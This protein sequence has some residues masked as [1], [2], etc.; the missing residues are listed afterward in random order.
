MATNDSGQQQIDDLITRLARIAD[1]S[2][3]GVDGESRIK[4]A[5]I[6]AY[7]AGMP[8]PTLSSAISGL[9]KLEQEFGVQLR[10]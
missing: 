3:N 7:L 10:Q 8:Q 5:V 2:N 9:G 1:T 6:A 4:A